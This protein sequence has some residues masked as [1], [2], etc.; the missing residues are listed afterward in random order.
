MGKKNHLDQQP[1]RARDKKK[2]KKSIINLLSACKD[3][4]TQRREI[5][6]INSLKRGINTYSPFNPIIPFQTIYSIKIIQKKKDVVCMK[7]FTLT[8]K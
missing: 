6:T 4:G 5:I 3:Y 1:V 7:M 8:Y 2:K